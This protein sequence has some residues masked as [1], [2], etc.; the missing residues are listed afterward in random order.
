MIYFSPVGP[1]GT[2]GAEIVVPSVGDVHPGHGGC[3]S[4]GGG[5]GLHWL[6][7]TQH[8]FSNENNNHIGQQW[9]AHHPVEINIWFS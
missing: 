6:G 4:F 7:N 2:V 9:T 3:I 5:G 8:W 1:M